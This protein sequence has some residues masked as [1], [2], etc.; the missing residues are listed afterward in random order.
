MKLTEMIKLGIKGYKPAEIKKLNESGIPSD[1][2][3][4]LAESGYSISEIDELISISDKDGTVQPGN[5]GEK[6]PVGPPETTG[7]KGEEQDD[8]IE[9][10]NA[11]EKEIAELKK[12]NPYIES[13]IFNSVKNVNLDT[14]IEYKKGGVRYNFLAE[15]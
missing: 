8:Y 6:E 2:I 1:E 12:T 13:N 3:I 10:I 9:R 7:H 14:A 4:K 11:Q 15:Y 5:E